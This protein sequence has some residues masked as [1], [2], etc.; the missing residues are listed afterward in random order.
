LLRAVR[1]RS[2]AA[3]PA[4]IERLD[5]ED[6]L[7][8]TSGI[9]ALGGFGKL[10]AAAIPQIEP[11]L[12]NPNEYL[13]VAATFLVIVVSYPWVIPWGQLFGTR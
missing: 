4:L 6:W 9:L 10:A 2:D 11:W 7:I 12:E 13:R 8:V 1:P 3:V 5:D